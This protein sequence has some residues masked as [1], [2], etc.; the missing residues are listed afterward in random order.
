MLWQSGNIG[1]YLRATT[2]I[3]WDHPSVSSKAKDVV[4]EPAD[5]IEHARRLFEWVRD[6]IPHSKDIG[7]RTVT[8][9]ASEVLDRGTGICHAKSH[10]LAAMCRSIGIPAGLCY[11]V[12]VRAAPYGGTGIHGFNALYLRSVDKWVRVDARGNT[13]GIDA[14]FDTEHEKLA[15]PIDPARGDLFMYE[16]VFSD[17]VPQ[18]V[19]MLTR[20]DDREE[21]WWHFPAKIDD[22]LLPESD[23]ALNRTLAG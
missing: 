20:F 21:M 19:D 7:D 1:D 5:D 14:Q 10:L 15:F 6:Q 4:E 17:P 18:V 3:D 9:K 12:F 22:D 11:H 23:R 8:C 16:T 2:V 13:E